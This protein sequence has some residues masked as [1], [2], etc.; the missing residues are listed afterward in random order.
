MGKNV[1]IYRIDENVVDKFEQ[2]MQIQN[3]YES[4]IVQKLM[5][6]YIEKSKVE[7]NENLYDDFIT[8]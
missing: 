5:W 1:V 4:E 3:T 8:E 6:D 7:L 2:L